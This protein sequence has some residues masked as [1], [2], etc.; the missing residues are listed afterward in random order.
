MAAHDRM[1]PPPGDE[2]LAHV[3]AR[4]DDLCHRAARGVA[5]VSSF[6][7]PREGM[8]ASRAL[9]LRRSAG[10]AVFLGGIPAA[11]RRRVLI[12]P[13]FLEGLLDPAPLDAD[14]ASA[15][16]TAGFSEYA[17]MVRDAVT[18]V[19][20]R[21]SGFRTLTHRD[22][23]GSVLGLG[24]DRDA[25]GDIVVSDTTPEAYVVTDARI[26]DFLASHLEK[27]ANDA[28]RVSR[29]AGDL[30]AIP[31][32]RLSPIRDTVASARLDCVVAALCNLSRDA[33]QT[34][35][36]GGLVE[37]NYEPVLDC[38]RAIEPPVTLSVRGV[39]KFLVE[40]FDGETRKG[41]MRVV[42]GKYV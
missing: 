42:A 39:G 2:A 26:A 40:G 4:L 19:T 12:L 5:A 13:D 36:R 11:E 28:V 20:I 33:A 27:V 32:R 31:A 29:F 35:I 34:A 22:Y 3:A 7:T 23:L 25:L 14:P 16:E 38:D 24:L 41:R 30:A 37:L 6:L 18:V 9:A 8:Y 1:A 21:A 10:T 17:A 15:L